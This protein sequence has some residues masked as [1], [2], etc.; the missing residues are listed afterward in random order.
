M[1]VMVVVTVIKELDKW[2]KS[3]MHVCALNTGGEAISSVLLKIYLSYACRYMYC[4]CKYCVFIIVN[5]Q[6][7]LL[8]IFLVPGDICLSQTESRISAQLK[9][10]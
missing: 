3:Q 8:N 10:N 7:V 5:V 4:D 1:L 9:Y 6:F 2:T